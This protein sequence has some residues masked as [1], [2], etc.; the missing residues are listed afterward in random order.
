FDVADAACY[1]RRCAEREID[2]HIPRKSRVIEPVRATAAVETSGKAAA[3]L[4]RERSVGRAA[5]QV[6][7]VGEGHGDYFA[8][9]GPRDSKGS[10]YVRSDQG[11][12]AG[13]GVDGDREGNRRGRREVHDGER[14]I[15]AAALE[16]Q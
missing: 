14:I 7:E 13:A 4:E 11:V 3:G 9:I 10:G 6:L 1:S 12:G 16:G 15:A 5:D 8:G 2:H